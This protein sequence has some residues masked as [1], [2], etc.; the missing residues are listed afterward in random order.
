MIG[1]HIPK[2][3]TSFKSNTIRALF[4]NIDVGS[5]GPIVIH[6]SPSNAIFNNKGQSADVFFRTYYN[7]PRSLDFKHA[8]MD[9]N[10]NFFVLYN[11]HLLEFKPI[12]DPNQMLKHYS[13]INLG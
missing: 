2:M 12:K 10:K 3:C 5:V 8:V 1:V 11:K 6:D 4:R 7:I 13:A 9:P